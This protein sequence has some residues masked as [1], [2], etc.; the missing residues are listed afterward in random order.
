[1]IDIHDK[2]WRKIMSE[3]I[4]RMNVLSKEFANCRTTF[5]AMGDE[6]RQLIIIALLQH[7]EGLRVMEL[8]KL[9]NLSRP[10]VSHHLKVLRE[11]GIIDMYKVGTK[12][13]YHINGIADAWI[14]LLNLLHHMEMIVSTLTT[15]YDEWHK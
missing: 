1:M 8:T 13:F 12:N 14:E 7:Y 3:V 2:D 9:T 10:A 15:F 6:N 5:V 4:E 11:V